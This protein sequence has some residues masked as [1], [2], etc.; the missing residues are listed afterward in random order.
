VLV[1]GLV[2][3]DGSAFVARS[4]QAA[5]PS[6]KKARVELED[7]SPLISS[8]QSDSPLLPTDSEPGGFVI[9]E[10]DGH[11][12]CRP[13]T[14]E[15]AQALNERDPALA[16]HVITPELLA[17]EQQQTGLKIILRG[18]AQLESFPEAKAAFVKAAAIWESLIRNPITIVLDV[19]FGPTRFGQSFGGSTLA[20]TTFTQFSFGYSATRS[21]LIARASN[22][23]ETTLYNALP[24]GTVPTDIG[25]T[26]VL[27]TTTPVHRALGFMN[28]VGDP[29]AELRDFGP[30]PAIGFN[31]NFTFD[32][33]PSNGIDRDKFDFEGT[34]IH[35]IGHALGFSSRVGSRE[36]SPSSTLAVSML[37]LFRFRPGVALTTFPTAQR[38][39]SSGG[40][41]NFFNGG[42]EI[43]LST[44][45]ADGTG[46]DR[47]QAAHWKDDN[48][49]GRYIGI[50]DPTGGQG[51]RAVMTDNDL[52]AFD[53]FGYQIGG[54]GNVVDLTSGV[55]E[56]GSISS[57]ANTCVLSATQY[58]I[59]V[60]GGATQL[61]VEL[62]GNQDVD[63][64]V[65]FNQQVTILKGTVGADFKS[66]S[67][68]NTESITIAP[69][70]TPALQQ[71]DYFIA[72]T[73][74]G[75]GA[76]SF[77]VTA[78]V[79][80]VGPPPTDTVDLTS[81]VPQMGSV[82]RAPQ[83]GGCQLGSTQYRIDVPSGA[84]QLKI[85]LS[86]N[87]D[88]DLYA[89]FGQ[90]VGLQGTTPVADHRSQ[91]TTGTESITVTASSS[92]ALRQGAYFIGV[93]NCGTATATI[94]VTATVGS[95]PPPGGD[96]ID[97]TSGVPQMGS[98]PAARGA[99]VCDLGPTQYRIQV[100]SGA[101]QLKV[102]L[103]GN[104]DVD[105]Y[106]RFNQ[107]VTE[108][109]GQK[110]AD[111]RSESATGTES[112]TIRS[113]DTPPLSQG[114]YFIGVANCSTS[115]ANITVTATVTGSQSVDQSLVMRRARTA[116][117]HVTTT[118][119]RNA[120]FDILGPRRM[121][122]V[123]NNNK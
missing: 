67:T 96:T 97:L 66:D 29:D 39:L 88:V 49:I 10:E 20:S 100:P 51:E 48:L 5:R 85:D 26:T 99:S 106:V 57:Q 123:N 113:T 16:L 81:G 31:S 122:V 3:L 80:G 43:P 56:S 12:V 114:A 62:S 70:T 18:T 54:G 15:E 32:F 115:V 50:M 53:T 116:P 104:Q 101:T 108:Q 7:H 107:R 25:E 63:L 34:A 47:N 8:Q 87:Q 35:E 110:I 60:P 64:Y 58:R 59:Q 14:P 28:A 121:E 117:L 61:K 17:E 77:T 73:N 44:G 89:R 120:R 27:F 24:T 72:V 6:S 13:A 22:P 9:Y 71:G 119:T 75:P 82:A 36:L 33:D 37:D 68:G 92:P 40:E 83:S 79:G 105:L 55:P 30:P 102:D 52:T 1:I 109:G 93:T 65:R 118:L 111:R 69:S 94:M 95:A 23:N 90:R 38:V 84:T 2:L 91:S 112:V 4:S 74:C 11:S 103:V 19:D 41:Q 45:R 86:G 98:V 46:G 42:P 21:R 78:T 76:A